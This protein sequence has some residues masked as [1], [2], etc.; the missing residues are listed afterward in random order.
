MPVEIVPQSIGAIE[1]RRRFDLRALWRVSAWGG[2]AAA[3]LAVAAFTTQTE[4]GSQRLAEIVAPEPPAQPAVAI[5]IPPQRE[6]E[7]EIARL[8]NQLRTLSADRDRLAERVAGLEHAIEDVTGS[9]RQQAAQTPPP[10]PAAAAPAPVISAPAATETTPA[11]QPPAPA[12]KAEAAPE[13]QPPPVIAKTAEPSPEAVPLPPA[14]VAALPPVPAV[15]PKQEIGVALASSANLDVLHL[16]WAALKANFG[17]A[18]TGLRPTAAREQRGTTTVYRLVLGPLPTMAAATKLC[19]RL[20][21][22]RAVCHTGKF[23]GEPL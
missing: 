23:S 1:R 19:A 14:R 13:P 5:T 16:Q 18:L 12:Q 10:A 2:A 8:Q 22:A 4:I 11:E 20:T 9:I 17:P 21:A 7:W 6:Q 15:P 3:A